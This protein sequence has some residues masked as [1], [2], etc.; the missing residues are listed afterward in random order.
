[1][2][3]SPLVPI[4]VPIVAFVAAVI[5]LGMVYW[6]EAHPGWKKHA[7]APGPGAAEGGTPPAIEAGDEAD[8]ELAPAAP[9][10]KAA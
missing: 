6:A 1:M 5:W 2:T 10:H 7:A 3:G 9:S 4:V 8:K